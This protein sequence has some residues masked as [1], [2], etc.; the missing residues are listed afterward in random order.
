MRYP[1]YPGRVS[2]RE[3][4]QPIWYGTEVPR[5]NNG[6]RTGVPLAR[7]RQSLPANWV[8][9]FSSLLVKPNLLRR[10]LRSLAEQNWEMP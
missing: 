7:S 10:R 5:S 8:V 1:G 9:L 6:S 3:P 4:S 2:G